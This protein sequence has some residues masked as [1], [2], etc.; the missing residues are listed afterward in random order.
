MLAKVKINNIV[1]VIVYIGDYPWHFPYFLHSCRYNPSVVI[2]ADNQERNLDLPETI[3]SDALP[4]GTI[5]TK[6]FGAGRFTSDYSGQ[7]S[8]WKT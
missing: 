3:R 1:F 8:N 4:F 2:F 6:I 5:Q 7:V